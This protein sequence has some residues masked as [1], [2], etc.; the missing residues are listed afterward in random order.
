MSST[1]KNIQYP[2][3]YYKHPLNKPIKLVV[4][5]WNAD[6]HR[7][8]E[9]RLWWALW[10]L[11]G[12]NV[13]QHV[14]LCG[15]DYSGKDTMIQ[16][17]LHRYVKLFPG[18]KIKIMSI[19]KSVRALGVIWSIQDDEEKYERLNHFIEDLAQHNI[20]Y[21]T[22]FDELVLGDKFWLR[23]SLVG[24][25][26]NNPNIK[27]V[28]RS[29]LPYSELDIAL[30]NNQ[31]KEEDATKQLKQKTE[32]KALRDLLKSF[33]GMIPRVDKPTP[34]ARYKILQWMVKKENMRLPET[35]VQ[36]ISSKTTSVDWYH[37]ILEKIRFSRE[38]EN[39]YKSN[40]N[41]RKSTEDVLLA[42]II[43][44][45]RDQVVNFAIECSLDDTYKRFEEFWSNQQFLCDLPEEKQVMLKQQMFICFAHR[46]TQK[47]MF[48]SNPQNRPMKD[49]CD[50][51]FWP[52]KLPTLSKISKRWMGMTWYV[53]QRDKHFQD[54]L[55]S[56][57]L[58]ASFDLLRGQ[59]DIIESDVD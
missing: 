54:S 43:N 44:I 57:V 45:L 9:R 36:S 49:I 32:T 15:D 40:D 1:F 52:Y 51:V 12:L 26:K 34:K 19:A 33:Q 53:S 2:K 6:A 8:L 16:H 4:H 7:V 38:Y 13:S 47:M 30:K 37:S 21:I 28:C 31:Y 11:E 23:K 46:F 20:L 59:E 22:D 24:L 41:T 3:S 29:K 5:Q 18:T 50:K 35:L 48:N 58:Y 56:H 42:K 10:D 17:Y 27:L 25:L 55:M 39:W 14:G